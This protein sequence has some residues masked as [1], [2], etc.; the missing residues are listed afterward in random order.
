MKTQIIVLADVEALTPAERKRLE[1]LGWIVIPK[2]PGLSVSV[3][4]MP[5]NGSQRRAQRRSKATRRV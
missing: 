3:M 2:K 1:D 4:A 5:A